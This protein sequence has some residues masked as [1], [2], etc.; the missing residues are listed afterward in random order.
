MQSIDIDLLTATNII[1]TSKRDLN[2]LRDDH[3]TF[4]NLFKEAQ[5]YIDKLDYEFDAL[6]TTR[7]RKVP[8][9]HDEKCNDERITDPIQMFKINTVLPALDHI[10]SEMNKRFNSDYTGILKDISL[11]SLK[12]IE[13]IMKKPSMFP[14]DSIVKLCNT[15]KILDINCLRTEYLQFTSC[16][17]EI[18]N[19]FMLPVKIQTEMELNILDNEELLFTD[20][21]SEMEENDK[22][23]LKEN[24]TSKSLI[25]IFN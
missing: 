20:S 23:T 12:R 21:D 4:D 6:R 1:E 22:K 15:Y 8:R 9:K 2:A 7:I 18:K 24:K 13:E 10:N 11:L 19:T 3:T 25:H 17:S 5:I 16:F 14:L